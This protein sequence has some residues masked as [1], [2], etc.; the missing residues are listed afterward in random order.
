MVTLLS[1][2]TTNVKRTPVIL[3][4]RW[5]ILKSVPVTLGF[6]AKVFMPKTD[7]CNGLNSHPDKHHQ[8]YH[9]Q[10]HQG[11]SSYAVHFHAPVIYCHTGW[12]IEFKFWNTNN[13]MSELQLQIWQKHQKCIINVAYLIPQKS[14]GS[15]MWRT[16]WNLNCY[17]NHIT[18]K[19]KSCTHLNT[20]KLQSR[21][22]LIVQCQC[23]D[24]SL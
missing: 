3:I 7:R 8:T 16:G 9:H 19:V 15:F 5:F 2:S 11:H 12:Y 6:K 21:S 17:Y 14:Y 13:W 23:L 20:Q 10:Y 1:L 24:V 4:T 18:I 22:I